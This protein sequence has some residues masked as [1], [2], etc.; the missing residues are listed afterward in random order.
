[1][2]PA[3]IHRPISPARAHEAA[4]A[5]EPS[6]TTLFSL[7]PGPVNNGLVVATASG[8]QISAILFAGNV[9]V[10]KADAEKLVE[11]LMKLLADHPPD[12]FIVEQQ[13]PSNPPAARVQH[14]V[15]GAI[16]AHCG[17]RCTIVRASSRRRAAK[18]EATVDTSRDHHSTNRNTQYKRRKVDSVRAALVLVAEQKDPV[19]AAACTRALR[20]SG[21]TDDVADAII[22]LMDHISGPP[23][24]ARRQ[25]NRPEGVDGSKR[26]PDQ[27]SHQ[28]EVIDLTSA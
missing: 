18:V 20:T 11:A 17:R 6:T 23:R 19:V 25:K 7:D 22:M 28:D 13:H 4:A 27:R 8:D 16:M 24:P 14:I 5:M 26:P 12:V 2:N 15:E 9:V 21:K 10:P 1:M 3:G